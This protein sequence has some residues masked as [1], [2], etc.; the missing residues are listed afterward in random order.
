MSRRKPTERA[1]HRA[2]ARAHAKIVR[3]LERL[4]RLAPG[5]AADR[6]IAIVSPAQVEVMAAARPCPLCRGS[7]RVDEHVALTSGG[8]R[9]RVARVAC[10]ACGS[11]RAVYFALREGLH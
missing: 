3:D 6:P 11:R 5:G 9:L 7:L 10:T 1:E 4:A 2:S 8:V